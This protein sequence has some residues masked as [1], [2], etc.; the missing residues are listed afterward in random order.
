MKVSAKLIPGAVSSRLESLHLVLDFP[1]KISSS[2]CEVGKWF[3]ICHPGKP[4]E[5][6]L[7]AEKG[8]SFKKRVSCL[9]HSPRRM[10]FHVTFKN[11]GC[12]GDAVFG[13][14]FIDELWALNTDNFKL[15]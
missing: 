10:H 1:S 9:L 14:R 13:K 15:E 2:Y 7:V 5:L 11:R 8:S 3:V 6:V 4:G 12:N